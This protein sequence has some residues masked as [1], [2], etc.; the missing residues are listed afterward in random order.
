M[1]LGQ[2]AFLGVEVAS[3]STGFGGNGDGATGNGAVVAGVVTGSAADQAGLTQG[4]EITSVAGHAVSSPS[5]ISA[6][7]ATHHPGDKITIG[8]TDQSGQSHSATVTLTTGPA[9]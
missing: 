7:L 5:G 3:G 4:D 2:T 6:T 9:A 1:H 8:W